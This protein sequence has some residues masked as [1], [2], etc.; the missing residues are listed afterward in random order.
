VI[1]GAGPAKVRVEAHLQVLIATQPDAPFALRMHRIGGV[2]GL[3]LRL[4]EV[5]PV[6][7][8]AARRRIATWVERPVRAT[9]ADFAVQAE[10]TTRSR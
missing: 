1:V 4:Q 3:D 7:S 5:H 8:T 6:V 9:L 2:D 10:R